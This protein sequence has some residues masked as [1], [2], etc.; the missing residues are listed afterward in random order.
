M[1]RPLL[2]DLF[3]IPLQRRFLVLQFVHLSLQVVD[4]R[5]QTL[6]LRQHPVLVLIFLLYFGLNL[7]DLPCDVILLLL[8]LLYIGLK[9]AELCITLS[10]LSN[11]CLHIPRLLLLLFLSFIERRFVLLFLRL[12]LILSLNCYLQFLLSLL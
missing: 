12:F 11:Q 6:Y 4:L 5:V 10:D 3:G 7:L 9:G 2:C 1:L 8:L